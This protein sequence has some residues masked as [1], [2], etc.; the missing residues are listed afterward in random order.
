[1]TRL[2][3]AALALALAACGSKKAPNDRCDELRAAV[4]RMY[5]AEL[6]ARGPLSP[7]EQ[8]RAAAVAAQVAPAMKAAIVDSCRADYWPGEVVKCMRAA[9]TEAAIDD[10]ESKLSPAARAHVEDAMQRVVA[11]I[12]PPDDT[13]GDAEDDDDQLGAGESGVPA[14]DAY[15]QAMQRYLDCDRVPDAVKHSARE[16]LDTMRAT[17]PMLKQPSTPDAA[18]QAAAGAC[19][20]QRVELDTSA[21]AMGCAGDGGAPAAGDCGVLAPMIVAV[22]AEQ[23]RDVPAD[24]QAAAQAQAKA[25]AAPLERTL[26]DTCTSGRWSASAT[27]CFGAARTAQALVACEARLTPDQA[28]ALARAMDDAT[29]QI[30]GGGSGDARDA[31]APARIPACD[32]YVAYVNKL[33]ACDKLPAADRA[34]MQQD[35]ALTVE[36]M[37]HLADPSLPVVKDAADTCAGALDAAKQLGAKLGCAA[38]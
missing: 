12:Q 22:L 11:R 13:P 6:T 5:A 1:M 17:W 14:C 29:Q 32:D 3:H 8:Q 35:M 28:Q 23:L 9:S 2:A 27:K 21:Q 33:L 34:R 26:V 15:A 25:L 38:Q 36:G 20:R 16:A 37:K 19:E 30:A 10:C 31:G 24:K 18:R 7:G 4:D